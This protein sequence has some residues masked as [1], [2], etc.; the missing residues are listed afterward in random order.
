MITNTRQKSHNHIK[1]TITCKLCAHETLS[2]RSTDRDHNWARR[3]ATSTLAL[4]RSGSMSAGLLEKGLQYYEGLDTNYKYSLTFLV[5]ILHIFSYTFLLM[6]DSANIAGTCFL[7]V[8]DSFC[9]GETIHKCRAFSS[10]DSEIMVAFP[11]VLLRIV[12]DLQKN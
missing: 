8:W 4:D 11:F 10:L 7:C 3:L 1:A 6:S 2:E 5:K 9:C 12:I